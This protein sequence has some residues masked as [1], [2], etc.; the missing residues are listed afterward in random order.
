MPCAQHAVAGDACCLKVFFPHLA[1]V[2]VDEVADHGEYVLV[3]AHTLN[4]PIACRGCGTPSA[5]LH[6]HYRRLLHD[7]PAAGRPVLIALTVRRLTCQNPDCVVRTFAEPLIGLTQRYARRTTLLRRLL[8]LMAL[9]L[10]GRAASRLLDLLGVR[11]GR[12]SL[13]QL[14]RALPDP[15]IGQVTVL[16]VDDFSKRRGHSYA[17]IMI[18]METHRPIDVLDDRTAD[19]LAQWLRNHP[20]VRVICRDR[21]GAYADG[22]RTGAPEATQIAD[23]FHLYQ[24]LCDAVEKTVIAC[25]ADLREP[26]DDEPEADTIEAGDPQAE[27]PPASSDAIGDGT[28]AEECRLVVRHR[29]RYAAVRELVGKG[30]KISAISRKL[31]LDR[32]TVRKF[33]RAECVEDLLTKAT[34]RSDLLTPYLP[35][36]VQRFNDGSTDAAR[37]TR[38]I[39]AQGYRGSP[40]TVRKYLHPFRDSATALRTPSTAPTVREATRW[41]TGHPDHLD[42]GDQTRLT[43]LRA[44]S[45]RLDSTAGHVAAFAKMMTTLTGTRENLQAWIEAVDADD[46]PDLHS[47]TRGIRRDLDAVINGLSLPYSSGAVEGNVTRAKALKRSRYGRANLDLLR[48]LILCAH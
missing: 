2:V 47:F 19:A 9:A 45:P 3:T 14:V 26:S 11:I 10:A 46:L 16:G 23:R 27:E 13:I 29:E 22:A 31:H 32:K 36:L 42:E 44:R 33:A 15:E 28:P 21:A 38:E 1:E 7:L 39:R 12:D 25:R 4:G 30:W 37:L 24:N 34:G 5:R 41:I 20:G 35:Y 8:E 43:G 6:G 17:T 48:K 40:Q 18:N